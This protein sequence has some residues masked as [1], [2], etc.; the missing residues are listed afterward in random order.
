[1]GKYKAYGILDYVEGYL[2]GGYLECE[3]NKDEWNNMNQNDKKQYLKDYGKLII[4]NYKLLSY[5]EINKLGIEK[6]IN[7]V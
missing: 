6:A 5:G 7:G 4:N 1:M 3:I 2:Q